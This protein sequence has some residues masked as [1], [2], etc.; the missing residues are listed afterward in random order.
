M[1]ANA[2]G[3]LLAGSAMAELE[4]PK[5]DMNES[6]SIFISYV[7]FAM[8]FRNFALVEQCS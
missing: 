6:N 7:S 8:D 2:C 4:R 1:Q 3:V 5:T